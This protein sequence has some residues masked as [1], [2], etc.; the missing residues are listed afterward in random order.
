M[1]A[2]EINNIQVQS[3]IEPGLGSIRPK[4]VSTSREKGVQWNKPCLIGLVSAE[5]QTIRQPIRTDESEPP[6][7]RDG[8]S[9]S[10]PG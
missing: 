3:R 2:L 1:I 9:A 5:T 10:L 4:V 8:M 7:Q 6:R